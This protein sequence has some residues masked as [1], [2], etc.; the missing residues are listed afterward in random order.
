MLGSLHRFVVAASLTALMACQAS[1][2]T[3]GSGN[4]HPNGGGTSGTGGNRPETGGA[5]A[6]GSG[7]AS[8][9]GNPAAFVESSLISGP[10]AIGRS[11]ARTTTTKKSSPVQL[12]FR[13]PGRR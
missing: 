7:A 3:D 12:D 8:Q 6:G 5:S 9:P 10:I 11:A 1:P 13:R 4:G 2:S